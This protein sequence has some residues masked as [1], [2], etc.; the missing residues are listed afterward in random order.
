M[1]KLSLAALAR[2]EANAIETLFGVALK[3]DK[4]KQL[5]ASCAALMDVGAAKA[6]E[7]GGAV[8][9]KLAKAVG[10]AVRGGKK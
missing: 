2:A 4:R 10:A 1:P 6:L 3:G 5:V 7:A 8:R 9:V